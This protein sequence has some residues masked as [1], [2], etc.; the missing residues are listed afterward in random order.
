MAAGVP[1]RLDSAAGA[2]AFTGADSTGVGAMNRVGVKSGS[3]L[4]AAERFDSPR[5]SGERSRSR[6]QRGGTIGRGGS[7]SSLEVSGAAVRFDSTIDSRP[8]S[9]SGALSTGDGA[10][11]RGGATLAVGSCGGGAM[12]RFAPVSVSGARSVSRFVCGG[13]EALCGSTGSAAFPLPRSGGAAAERRGSSA[14]KPLRER[15]PAGGGP[16]R[17]GSGGAVFSGP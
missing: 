7:I 2:A 12:L 6:S 3:C 1:L 10:R 9:R 4:R 15:S 14:G 11:N 8:D 13:A 5:N 16:S 17:L